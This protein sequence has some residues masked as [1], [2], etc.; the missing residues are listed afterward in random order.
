MGYSNSIVFCDLE[1]QNSQYKKKDTDVN[2]G[3][4]F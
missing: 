1:N 2:R 3:S 4:W